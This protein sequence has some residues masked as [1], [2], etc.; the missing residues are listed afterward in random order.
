[1]LFV[2]SGTVEIGWV[3]DGDEET[4]L[5]GAGDTLSMPIGVEHSFRNTSSAPAVLFVVRGTEDPQMPSFASAPV[6]ELAGV[7]A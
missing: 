1:M 6:T 7:S 2:Q 4:L 3:N 5:M